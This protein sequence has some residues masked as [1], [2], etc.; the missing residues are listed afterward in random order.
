MVKQDPLIAGDMKYVW[1]GAHVAAVDEGLSL[2]AAEDAYAN[3]EAM[4]AG[5]TSDEGHRVREEAALKLV[6]EQQQPTAEKPAA[7][8]YGA[9]HD[10]SQVVQEQN[11][12]SN[13]DFGLIRID[14]HACNTD[15]K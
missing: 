2:Y 5:L 11:E 6:L 12:K 13:T 8:V 1:G 15:S 7:L 4:R 14:P 9:A 10:F 3:A